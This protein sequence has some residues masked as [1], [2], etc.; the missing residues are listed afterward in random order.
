MPRK[1][2]QRPQIPRA[3]S[4]DDYTNATDRSKDQAKAAAA[5]AQ[6]LR[7]ALVNLG[8]EEHPDRVR[9]RSGQDQVRHR[10]TGGLVQSVS[11]V[12]TCRP[13]HGATDAGNGS[14]R[15]ERADAIHRLG[16]RAERRGKANQR[17]AAGRRTRPRARK[18]RKGIR[19][20]RAAGKRAGR[21]RGQAQRGHSQRGEPHPPADQGNG[22]FTSRLAWSRRLREFA[23]GRAGRTRA[24]TRR[25]RPHEGG[26]G[27]AH[28]RGTDGA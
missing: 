12:K 24:G 27:P 10:C 8:T 20:A 21:N 23:G 26:A 4:L 9:D 15:G 11:A 25:D 6:A 17:D 13:D 7:M 14:V 18:V 19:K 3:K 22:R 1:A 28:H 5:A 2:A 16:Q